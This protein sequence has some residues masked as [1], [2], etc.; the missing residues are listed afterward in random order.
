MTPAPFDALALVTS[1]SAR[2]YH[3]IYLGEVEPAPGTTTAPGTGQPV[4]A[5][6]EHGVL[7]LGPPRS[8]KTAGVVVP[9]VLAAAGPVLAASTK[10]DL[11]AVTAPARSRLGGCGL[12]DPSGA[13]ACPRGVEPVGWS[14]LAAAR[15]WDGAVLVAESMVRA[16]RPGNDRGE[17]AHWTERAGALLAAV[18]H[19]GARSD[20]RMSDVV[21][22]IDRHEPDEIR[23]A[24]AREGADRAL[25]L[26]EGILATDGREQS[27]I[28]S[29]ASG[30]LAGY[31]TDA[32]LASAD[33]G[34]LD[35]D[36][37][38]DGPHTLYVCAS[39][40][41]Q[42][43]AAPL[44][45]GLLRDVRSA[46]YRRANADPPANFPYSPSGAS[47]RA[48]PPL[49]LVLDELANIA[50]LHDL[51][52]LV[53][54]GGSQGVVTLACLQDLSQ[55]RAR[56][57]R[58]AD[59]FL[60]LF[61]TKLVFPGIGDTRTLEAVSLLAGECDV[62]TT[63][64]TRGARWAGLGGTR[65]RATRTIATRRQRVLPVDAIARGMPGRVLG[66][67]GAV[68]GF[69]RTTPW[70]TTSPWREVVLDARA[71]EAARAQS[72]IAGVHPAVRAVGTPP[73]DRP[74]ER[75]LPSAPERAGRHSW[76]HRR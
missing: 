30:V 56:W 15:T 50:P 21:A 22:A 67:D 61:G 41:T 74:A 57:E 55:A 12:Y 37:L 38:L 18:L 71:R 17:G 5:H 76:G 7:V 70:F 72:G 64:V 35:V 52:A 23:A 47:H 53:A 69:L 45:A 11:L 48:P 1:A 73:L 44:V 43:H 19:G 39:S 29:T 36:A 24:L 68:P 31:R 46:A 42:R 40:D 62:A 54:E 13:V 49:L 14:P 66:V 65:P 60:S 2:A 63:S 4:F 75:R 58:E 26:F 28:W 32:A 25:D 27:G 9:N 51:P 6:S 34:A 16:A 8:G 59:G 10:P 33:R 20:R 3:G